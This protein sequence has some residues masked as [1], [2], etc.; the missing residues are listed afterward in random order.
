M[1]DFGGESVSALSTRRWRNRRTLALAGAALIL[2]AGLIHLALA[3]EHF[4]EAAYLGW[5]FVADFVGASVAASGICRGRRWGWV[6]GALVA[7]GAFVAYFVGGM[8]GL[9]GAEG[10]HFLG[11]LGVVAKSVEALFLVLC[12][13]KFTET[14][15]GA[16]RWA[17]VSG[18]AAALL[19]PG[20]AVALGLLG[21][22][23]RAESACASSTPASGGQKMP[24]WAYRWKATSP[25][26]QLGDRYTLVVENT[27]EEDQQARIRTDIMDHRVHT[28][29]NVID[30]ELELASG[31]RCELTAV[32]DY[33]A[34]NHF[35]TIIGSQT[36]DLGL[37]VKVVDAEGTE[38]A[39]FSERAFL[40]QAGKAKGKGKAEDKAH[41]DKAHDH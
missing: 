34:A 31:E 38:T 14:F 30:E 20:L 23:A 2:V 4:G 3:P 1:A 40:T 19:V 24:G 18:S 37:A 22:A 28:N 9:P 7:L 16:R 41:E 12:A 25:A 36:Q 21:G 39:R 27:G 5:L 10:H 29:T 13:F 35:N 11:P 32:N 8:V 6:L 33:G 26:I 17:L 15:A